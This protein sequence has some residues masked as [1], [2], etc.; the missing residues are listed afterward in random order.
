MTFKRSISSFRSS[1][2]QALFLEAYYASMKQLPK[3]SKQSRIKTS[4]GEVQYYLYEHPTQKKAPL[5]LLPG[6]HSGA[7][8]WEANIKELIQERTVIV[9]DAIGDSGLSKQTK[10]IKDSKDQAQWVHEF[11]TKLEL[12]PVH[13]VGHS[14]GGWLASNHA[15]HYPE[16]IKSLSLLEPVFVIEGLKPMIFLK[17]IPASLPFLPKNFKEDLLKEISGSSEVDLKD[18]VAR[19]ISYSS[20][21]FQVQLPIPDLITGESLNQIKHPI[22]IRVADQSSLHNSEKIVKKALLSIEN[23]DIKNWKNAT[24]SLPMEYPE[25]ISEE[26][27]NFTQ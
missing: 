3:P 11:I 16:D 2:G 14:F 8:M 27:I 25:E 17:S 5:L 7:P 21:Y 20:E 15:T 19:M 6:R 13:S 24:H 1:Q 18:P 4:Y 10:A 22:Y 26:L 9:I 23:V 12:G